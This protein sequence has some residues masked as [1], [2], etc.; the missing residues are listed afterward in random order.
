MRAQAA[1]SL[2]VPLAFE[3]CPCPRMAD[4]LAGGNHDGPLH[5]RDLFSR[6]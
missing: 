1:M 2:L 5:N 4:G 6:P 3:E